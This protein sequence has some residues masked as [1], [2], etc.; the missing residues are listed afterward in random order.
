[1]NKNICLY[2]NIKRREKGEKRIAL[3]HEK[4]QQR[5]LKLKRIASPDENV[6]SKVF[7]PVRHQNHYTLQH[8]LVLT[9]MTHVMWRHLVLF[10]NLRSQKVR[11]Q[12]NNCGENTQIMKASF[13][14]MISLWCRCLRRRV[15]WEFQLLIATSLLAKAK[16]IHLD[17]IIRTFSVNLNTI[18]IHLQI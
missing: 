16:V 18:I 11:N 13:V 9:I 8:L 4:H 3:L 17:V 1:M 10:S 15:R 5:K 6:I 14:L 2:E 12:S 7:S